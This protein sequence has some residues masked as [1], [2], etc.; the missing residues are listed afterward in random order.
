MET[1]ELKFRLVL[2]IGSYLILRKTL[3]VMSPLHFYNCSSRGSDALFC[4]HQA[5]MWCTHVQAKHSTH[6]IKVSFT[7]LKTE[8]V[9]LQCQ[10]LDPGF[11][12]QAY[13]FYLYR[14][15]SKVFSLRFKTILLKIVLQRVI[16][17]FG[18]HKF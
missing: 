6:K 7:Y 5:F 8:A 16:L 18:L 1:L 10:N 13:S 4:G 11:I 12:L 14:T 3:W 15:Q 2:N 17:G 9:T